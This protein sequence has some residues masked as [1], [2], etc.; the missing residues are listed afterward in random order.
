MRLKRATEERIAL[1]DWVKKYSVREAANE[2]G[3]QRDTV[4][5]AI[6]N[7]RQITLYAIG[8]RI[9]YAYEIKPAFKY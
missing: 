3:V 4:Y 7:D 1:K 9:T 2:M 8:K 6:E 5:K